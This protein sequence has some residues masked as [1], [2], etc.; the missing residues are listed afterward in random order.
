MLE[1]LRDEKTLLILDNF[2]SVARTG[3]EDILKF[4]GVT[5][6]RA[7]RDKP[8]YFKVLVTSRELIPSGFHQIRLKGLDKRESK[9]LMHR[10]YAPYAR[11]GKQQL[12]DQQQDALYETTQGIP[13]IIKHC[14]G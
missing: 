9:Q 10:L 14:Y 11:S 12:T 5:A 6:K 1:M 4:F 8:D 3:E 2:E 7:L 13:L